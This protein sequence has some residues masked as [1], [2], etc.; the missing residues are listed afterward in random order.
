MKSITII[1]A[2]K[3]PLLEVDLEAG[4]MDSQRHPH[5]SF[6]NSN[7]FLEQLSTINQMNA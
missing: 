4:L 5:P 2:E 7:K 6:S 1:C 3:K